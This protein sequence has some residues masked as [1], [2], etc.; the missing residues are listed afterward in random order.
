MAITV[1]NFT[2][3]M[4]AAMGVD[5]LDAVFGLLVDEL[6]E[7]PLCDVQ[8]YCDRWR[9]R[10]DAVEVRRLAT[11]VPDD[12]DTRK[13]TRAA[14][15]GGRRSKR[16]ARQQATRAAAAK[17]NPDLADKMAKGDLS[18]EQMDHI[19]GATQKNEAAATDQ[20]L[21]DAITDAPVDQAKTIVDK[22]LAD[23]AAHDKA[24][25]RHAAQ[26]RQRSVSRWTDRARD[27]AALTVRGDEATV[28]ELWNLCLLYTSPSPRDATL[29][30]MPS[31]A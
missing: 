9:G 4:H 19:A 23:N 10:L 3:R 27:L 5:A 2:E 15:A 11:R 31:S 18:T 26:R 7:L 17:K 8:A 20:G 30:R 24:E 29:S 6:D 12:G 1:D 16:A 28:D 14:T 13:A 21:I 25:Q 22:W